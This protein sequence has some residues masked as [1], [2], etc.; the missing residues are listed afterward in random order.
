MTDHGGSRTRSPDGCAPAHPV[1]LD[2]RA[3]GVLRV[4]VEGV[5][6]RDAGDHVVLRFDPEAR[7]RFTE[8]FRPRLHR[9]RRLPER[10]LPVAP[11]GA[12][13]RR[14]A[15]RRRLP[16]LKRRPF[17]HYPP[18]LD[19][20]AVIGRWLIE[21]AASTATPSRS[22]SRTSR[23]AAAEVAQHGRVDDGD[24]PR[25]RRLVRPGQAPTARAG[26]A[27]LLR[28]HDGR[29]ARPPVMLP[30]E[31]D[32]FITTTDQGK[33]DEIQVILD[34]RADAKVAQRGAD[35]AVEPGP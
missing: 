5:L 17:F 14:A 20:H 16:G 35:P 24:P 8:H 11:P 4:R 15:D 2:R 19:R 9:R 32:L 30:D 25:R 1:A 3:S 12:L 26:R 18:Y 22:S 34:R 31:F 29:A 6:A 10:G 7:V 23:N 33:A 21:S 27:H 28:G 13:Q